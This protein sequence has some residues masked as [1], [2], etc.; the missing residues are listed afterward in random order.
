MLITEAWPAPTT[1]SRN[2]A[3]GR[4]AVAYV[5]KTLTLGA[6]NK[7]NDIVGSFGA[8]PFC[9][10]A[11]RAYENFGDPKDEVDQIREWAAKAATM[12]CG[13]CGEHAAIAFCYLLDLEVKPLDYM[14]ATNHDHAFV[15][16]GRPATSDVSKPEEW[17]ADAVVVDAWHE[18]GKTYPASAFRAQ[19]I[20]GLDM[21]T[22]S[23]VSQ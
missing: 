7:L 16:I 19:M 12:K 17:G 4:E 3:R 9:V 6:G 1:A 14:F 21:I 5:K 18:G 22:A 15:V 20:H 23:F 13:N 8:S 10:A 11:L 2:L